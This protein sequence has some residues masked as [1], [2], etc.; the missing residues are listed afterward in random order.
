MTNVVDPVSVPLTEND[1][2]SIDHD[3]AEAELL[4][5]PKFIKPLPDKSDNAEIWKT[6]VEEA[7]KHDM[8]L[9][10]KWS[11]GVDIFLLFVSYASAMTVSFVEVAHGFQTGLFSA[12][13]SAFLVVSWSALQSDPSQEAADALLAISQQLILLSSGRPMNESVAYQRSAFTPPWW[14]MTVNCL[15]FTSLFLSLLTAILAMLLK[16]WLSAYNDGI[17]PVTLVRTV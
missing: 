2:N 10:S 3:A 12:I 11:E 1:T 16:E 8:V 6:Y 7:N 9:L 14:A 13:L 15:W 17:A 4:Q 5:A